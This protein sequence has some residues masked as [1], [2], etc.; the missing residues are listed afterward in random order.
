MNST[1]IELVPRELGYIEIVWA[2]LLDT[3]GPLQLSTW[4]TLVYLLIIYAA[5]SLPYALLYKFK[6]KFFYQ[7]KIQQDEKV[8]RLKQKQVNPQPDDWTCIKRLLLNHFVVLLPSAIGIYP[9]LL[10]VNA[11]FGVPLPSW[12]SIFVRCFL[13]FVIEDTF[14]YFGHRW[15]HTPWAYQNIHYL[16]H[17][18][19][20][21]IAM[22]SSYA[23]LAEF[24]FLGAG[25]AVGPALI[26][27]DHLFTLW[28]WT[29]I[30]QAEALDCHSGFDFP[31]HLSK[32]VPFYCG[33]HHHDHHHKT[34]GGNFA[35]TF[36][37][38]DY[39]LGTDKKYREDCE[40]EY[41]LKNKL[42]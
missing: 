17:Q 1:T 32:F 39:M 21:P 34:Y 27:V 16:H 26:G 42:Q 24:M 14:F 35:S 10:Y 18:Y 40:K 11:D 36:T 23:H 5:L 13:Y 41:K 22:A 7:Y 3:F 29:F 6:P 19:Q 20:S 30:R 38:W 33:P 31:W 37:W 28:V 4:V 9:A 25:F 2:Y 8:E 15:L 12:T